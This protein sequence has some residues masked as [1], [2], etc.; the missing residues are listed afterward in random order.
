MNTTLASTS[1]SPS[2]SRRGARLTPRVLACL[3]VVL[4]TGCWQ[5][6]LQPFYT[7]A[8]L[9]AE[10]GL[11]GA[12]R[13]EPDRKD[14]PENERMAWKFTPAGERRFDLVITSDKE[15]YEYEA[16]PFRLGDERYLDL[17]S[18]T[19]TVDTIPAHHLFRLVEVGATLK[20][21]TLNPDWLGKWLR[22]NPSS[23]AHVVVPSVE[24]RDNRDKDEF[25]LTADT[26]ALQRFVREHGEDDD[27][28]TGEIVFK[29]ERDPAARRE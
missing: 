2:V 6:S 24:E 11:A 29:K 16:R 4:L 23:L 22:R 9:I 19:R 20:V 26:A 7:A 12:W 8:D 15:R 25:V 17:Y 21:V 5:R 13:Q 10:P 3:A 28:F 14:S 27:F 18:K 1:T